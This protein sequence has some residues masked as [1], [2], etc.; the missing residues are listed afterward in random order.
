MLPFVKL[1]GVIVLLSA[2]SAVGRSIDVSLSCNSPLGMES[3]KIKGSQLT[4]SSA[5]DMNS[6]GPT[7]ARLNS[8]SAGGA[9]CPLSFISQESALHEFLEVDLLVE[10][11]ITEVITQG[12]FANGQGQEYAEHFKL[13]YWREDMEAFAEYV[14][15]KGL[16]IFLA[17]KDTFTEVTTRLEPPI[18]AT[19]IRIIPFS[20]HPRT[21]CMRIE[22][23][24]CLSTV[25]GKFLKSY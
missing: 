19:K 14:N 10:H 25:S 20:Y 8:D 3:G 23:K 21:V 24:G 18:R 22:L 11:T 6:V 2:T 7:R 15:K 17:N 5:Y 1:G 4:A 12:R 16:T 9:W 13:Q